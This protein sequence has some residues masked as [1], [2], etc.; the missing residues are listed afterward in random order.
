MLYD[1]V[2]VTSAILTEYSCDQ[3]LLYSLQRFLWWGYVPLTVYQFQGATLSAVSHFK[4]QNKYNKCI[5]FKRS[6]ILNYLKVHIERLTR[7][8]EI[9]C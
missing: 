2:F 8:P 6:F 5:C 1:H 4:L 9:A 7:T 3:S